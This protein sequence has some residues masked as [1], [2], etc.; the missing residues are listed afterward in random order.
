M[1]ANQVK[2]LR[3]SLGLTQGDLARLL[4]VHAVT[5]SRWER[6][7]AEPDGYN[8][9]MMERFKVQPFGDR[10]GRAV[11]AIMAQQGPVAALCWLL[12]K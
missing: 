8:A 7:V 3:D 1:T 2:T 4:N 12:R 11:R 6:G 9:A 5:V 10:T